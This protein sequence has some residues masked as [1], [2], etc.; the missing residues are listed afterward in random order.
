[1]TEA[2]GTSDGNYYEDSYHQ[3]AAEWDPKFDTNP[4][5]KPYT[6]PN[7]GPLQGM[8]GRGPT[9]PAGA[10]KSSGGTNVPPGENSSPE[11]SYG[12]PDISDV[13][14]H[15]WIE[16]TLQG[17]AKAAVSGF[18][19]PGDS[20]AGNL[21]PGSTQEVERAA[22]LAGLMV[23]GPAPVANKMADGT[24]GSFAGVGSRTFPKEAASS[25][26]AMMKDNLHPDTIWDATGVFKGSDGKLRYEIPD[27]AAKLTDKDW[28]YG[29]EGKLS[30]YLDH[31]ELYKAYPE[32]KDMNFKVA[33]Q[34]Q[35]GKPGYIASFSPLENKLTIDPS[36]IPSGDQ[37]ILDVMHHEIQHWIQGK[38]GFQTGS[39]P[40]RALNQ[41][42]NALQTKIDPFNN[43]FDRAFLSNAKLYAQ[44]KMSGEE[45]F[46][47]YMYSRNP[48]EIEANLTA[49]RRQLTD[50]QRR[51][52]SPNDTKDILEGS[53]NSLN[54]QPYLPEFN[55]PDLSQ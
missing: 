20:L 27:Q 19:A 5:N 26:E 10:F 48:G 47:K 50:E 44:I 9:E 25:A 23:F 3:A 38:E 18:K 46:G 4:Q 45:G 2:I 28:K 37:G 54:G 35:K 17:I 11:P 13:P 22:D 36:K 7:L 42:L 1:M 32:L 16:S 51:N 6:G 34:T 8:P 53:T 39:T 24:L 12:L 55:Y 15:D 43:M 41:A 49:A 52:F 33:D 29:E 31:P 21:P 30:D 40:Y 14:H